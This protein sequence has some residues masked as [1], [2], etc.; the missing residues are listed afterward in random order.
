M[1]DIGKCTKCGKPE[2]WEL[3]DAVLINEE[4]SGRYED[5]ACYGAGWLP[6]G[7]DSFR[8]SVRPDLRDAYAAF[9][10]AQP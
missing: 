3:L 1:T 4:D 8:H 6:T 7:E 9:R 2:H 5:I 10:S